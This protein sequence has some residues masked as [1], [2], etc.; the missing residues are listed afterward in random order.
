MVKFGHFFH[1]V[2][3]YGV[4]IFCTMNSQNIWPVLNIFI[5]KKAAM[6]LNFCLKLETFTTIFWYLE[7]L[8]RPLRLSSI[9]K[10]QLYTEWSVLCQL[11]NTTLQKW[12]HAKPY[13]LREGT[14]YIRHKYTSVGCDIFYIWMKEIKLVWSHRL[15]SWI[16][17]I[18]WYNFIIQ[19]VIARN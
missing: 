10:P 9:F 13:S 6:I 14:R 19:Y 17:W 16:N 2:T 3:Q 5:I 11:C 15:K 1:C 4:Q 7:W 8:N 12:G 18:L